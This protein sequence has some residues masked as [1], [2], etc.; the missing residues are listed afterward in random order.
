MTTVTSVKMNCVSSLVAII[1][2]HLLIRFLSAFDMCRY[3][4]AISYLNSFRDVSLRTFY[5]DYFPIAGL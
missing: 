5:R 2:D 3:V 1:I 4:R